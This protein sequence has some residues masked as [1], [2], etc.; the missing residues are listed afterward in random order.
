MSKD[1]F[2][3]DEILSVLQEIRDELRA[4]RPKEVTLD[5]QSTI[6]PDAVAEMISSALK[7][8]VPMRTL[9]AHR[10]R[11]FVTRI[12]SD[13]MQF[14]GKLHYAI[15]CR[16]QGSAYTHLTEVLRRLHSIGF[17]PIARSWRGELTILD[18]VKITTH[19]HTDWSLR[20]LELEGASLTGLI[21]DSQPSE[22]ESREFNIAAFPT[23]GWVMA[24]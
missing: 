16:S 17:V 2:V 15:V 11:D 18:R 4:H 3:T 23:L 22:A 19:W 8:S 6:K 21:T 1:E 10:T 9:E 20:N 7:R 24:S 13:A 14:S 5:V 12:L